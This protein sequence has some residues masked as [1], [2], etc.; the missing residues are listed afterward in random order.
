MS[1]TKTVTFKFLDVNH[2][3][4]A[5]MY[6]TETKYAPLTNIHIGYNQNA[7][8]WHINGQPRRNPTM[9]P[10]LQNGRAYRR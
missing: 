4:T 2:N 3:M 1:F 5:L 6:G 9:R 7:R 10:L 8:Y